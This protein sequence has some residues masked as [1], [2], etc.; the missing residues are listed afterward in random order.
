[1]E[2]LNLNQFE[3]LELENS[4]IKSVNGG[5]LIVFAFVAGMALAYWE[6]RIKD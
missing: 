4:E 3:I 2:N 5:G 6:C 1:M